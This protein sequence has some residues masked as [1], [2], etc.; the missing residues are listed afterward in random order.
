MG[1]ARL[2]RQAHRKFTGV[3]RSIEG[4]EERDMNIHRMGGIAAFALM[5]CIASVLSTMPAGAD[6]STNYSCYNFNYYYNNGSGDYYTGY[7]Y[8]PTSFKTYGAIVVGTKLEYEPEGLG[9]KSFNGGYYQITS[10]TDGYDSSYDKQEFITSYYDA[11][12]AAASLGVNTMGS[13]YVAGSIHVADRTT[14]YESGY[15]LKGTADA[16]FSP[17]Q[18]ADVSD[19][20]RFVVFGDSQSDP[21][22]NNF[23]EEY[24]WG[25][26]EPI[27]KSVLTSIVDEVLKLDP[28]PDFVVFLGDIGNWAV[29]YGDN[30]EWHIFQDIM[31]PLTDKGIKYYNVVGNHDLYDI[32]VLGD[33]FLEYTGTSKD[34]IYAELA[35]FPWMGIED[36]VNSWSNKDEAGSYAS[37]QALY[38]NEAKNL[39]TDFANTFNQTASSEY[40]YEVDPNN[41][42]NFS[43]E[44]GNSLF[45]YLDSFYIESDG[46]VNYEK[47]SQEG[48]DWLTNLAATSTA[49]HKFAFMHKPAWS[50]TG[51]TVDPALWEILDKYGFDVSFAADEH[52]YSRGTVDTVDG[53][54][55]TNNVTQII[56]AGAGAPLDKSFNGIFASDAYNASQYNF[57]VM[58]VSG[59]TAT[60]SA[61]FR[62]HTYYYSQE[63]P[64]YDQDGNPVYV[65]DYYDEDG[66]PHYLVDHTETDS[67]GTV[68]YYYVQQTQT[69]WYSYESWGGV[70]DSCS[71]TKDSCYSFTYYYND[72]NGDYYTGYFYAPTDYNGYAIGYKQYTTDENGQTGY[73]EITGV[74]D[75]ANNDSRSG[76]VY[77]TSYHDHES[78]N[79]YKLTDNNLFVT[80]GTAYLG[81]E[82]GYIIQSGVPSFYFGGGYYEADVG[83]YRY[84]FTF[85]YGNG[86]YYTGFVFAAPDYGY[87]N[88]YSKTTTDENG[89][90]GTYTITGVST[91][92]D[93]SKAGQVKVTSYYDHES[94]NTYKLTDN[95]LFVTIGTAYLG[96]ESGY[97]IQSGVPSFYFGGGYYEA[98]VAYAYSF[99]LTYGD[100]DY[101]TGT[102]Y[103]APEYG[104]STSY[105]KTINDIEGTVETATYTIT[106]VT[107][108]YDVSLEGQ[109]S[110]D[111]YYDA[112]SGRTI[113]PAS[114]P[115]PK[116]TNYLGSESGYIYI[117]GIAEYLFGSSGGTFYEADSV[118][119][120][121]NFTFTYGDGDYYTG[122]FCAEPNKVNG[123]N[124]SKTVTDENGLTGTY[125]ATWDGTTCSLVWSGYVWVTSYYDHESGQTL[126]PVWSLCGANYLGSE[127]D[128]IIQS[129]VPEYLFG[130]SGGT[131]YEADLVAY[132]YNFKLTYG[133]GDYYTGTVYAA[134]EYGYST[135][136]TKTINDIEGTVETATYTI[137]GV[138]T[139]Y[140]VSKAGQVY[141]DSY[142]DT[143]S[144][145]TY[146]PV[147]KGTPVGSSYLGSEYDYIIQSGVPEY[148]FGSYGGT[149]YEADGPP[150]AYLDLG[151]L[152]GT[153]SYAEGINDSGWVVGYSATA[154]GYSHAF[155]YSGGAMTDLGTLGGTLSYAYGINDSGWVV[156]ESTT[157]SGADHAFLYSGGTMTDLGTLG[158]ASSAARGINDSG[159]VV[160]YSNT[161]SGY[162]HA[163]LYS[164][165][166]MTDLGT[167]GGNYSYAYGINDSGQVVGYSTT[168]SGYW[169]AFLYSGGTMTDLGTL[170]GTLSYAY[171]INDSGQVV[172]YSAT[173]SG[174]W[175]AFLYY[176]G[177][178]TDL[179]TL[180]GTESLAW[181]INDSGQVVGYSA[182]A[183]GHWYA[184]L[185]YGGTMTDMGTL[186]G[187]YSYAYGINDSGQVVGYSTTASGYGDAFLYSP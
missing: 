68:H 25:A 47:I 109:V 99:K 92:Y 77:V 73:Y 70:D 44:V 10:I 166:A 94:G 32:D 45:V 141:V 78:R 98:D 5:V 26:G 23:F 125:T 102:V 128:Y 36:I 13:S 4:H 104:Y 180:G 15:A 169:H 42:L 67:D 28:Q 111:S 177:T 146:T 48:L 172:G 95:N 31:K 120:E 14:S 51:S 181:G 138:T 130:S 171:G 156:G 151:T 162:S 112:Q 158:G 43:F 142:Y 150:G 155:L 29:N 57:V 19:S 74:A 152:G 80:T 22:V 101:Y 89:Q 20:L 54:D 174:Y 65:V 127:H 75:A 27:N 185:Y 66:N 46:T 50:V 24:L 34:W 100:G 86:D 182:T 122:F 161:A 187:T 61:Y 108:G 40:N 39:Q 119:Y 135:S 149:F 116:G 153:Y 134:P 3:V 7:V 163:F 49:T 126:T 85:T 110:V 143:Q 144:G 11:N 88:Y 37:E 52:C 183:S 1:P 184:F 154:S 114:N 136:Y 176:G 38:S 159:Q 97:I 133:D 18:E 81:S 87:D 79:T 115:H 59:N 16:S 168:A 165:G 55:Y 91:G 96:S 118:C 123:T 8:A 58:D 145:N 132:A 186:G 69:V 2:G 64:V 178:M 9:E 71:I 21:F 41:P 62:D 157:A 129:G 124:Y 140:D 35:L 76:Q 147:S 56:S 106:G 131:F 33:K 121:Y 113:T 82:S 60:E 170:G 137:T 107:T 83:A 105:T 167:L 175:H 117:S 12:K 17:Y 6:P 63:E 30:N 179:G 164:G 90:T 148:L 173:A 93:V 53:Y 160:G 139:G 103:A 72:G 84:D